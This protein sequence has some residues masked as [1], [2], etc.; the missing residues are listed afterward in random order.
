MYRGATQLRVIDPPIGHGYED[1]TKSREL[2][3]GCMYMPIHRYVSK[4]DLYQIL[5]KSRLAL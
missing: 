2:I 4:N 3:N 1:P 5:E